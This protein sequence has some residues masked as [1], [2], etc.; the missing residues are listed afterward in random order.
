MMPFRSIGLQPGPPIMQKD[1]FSCD[2]KLLT[3]FT[4]YCLVLT[5]KGVGNVTAC[6]NFAR[7]YSRRVNLADGSRGGELRVLQCV[8][9]FPT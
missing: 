1:G 9:M 4:S 6:S 8:W 3:A 2:F 7:F 5:A